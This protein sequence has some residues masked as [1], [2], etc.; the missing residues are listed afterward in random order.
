MAKRLINF[1]GTQDFA[2]VEN[3]TGGNTQDKGITWASCSNQNG[4]GSVQGVQFLHTRTRLTFA[5]PHSQ[6]VLMRGARSTILRGGFSD[7]SQSGVI[8]FVDYL[9]NPYM[10]AELKPHKPF[11]FKPSQ[12]C[13]DNEGDRVEDFVEPTFEEVHAKLDADQK[14]ANAQD[15]LDQQGI[16]K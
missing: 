16:N 11:F 14:A 8:P 6:S 3:R 9:G 1:R 7:R 4:E 2:K 13:S 5:F 15:I 12:P 10:P